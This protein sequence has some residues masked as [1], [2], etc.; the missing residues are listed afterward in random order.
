MGPQVTEGLNTVW[1]PSESGLGQDGGWEGGR[2]GVVPSSRALAPAPRL[3]SWGDRRQ[4]CTPALPEATDER[5]MA[6]RRLLDFC[7]YTATF[8]Q[9]N[10]CFHFQRFCPLGMLW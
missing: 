10:L 9:P 4:V 5:K 7:H 6:L 8:S 1:V 3:G 2:E